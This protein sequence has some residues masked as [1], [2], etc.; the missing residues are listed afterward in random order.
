[1]SIHWGKLSWKYSHKILYG[2]GRCTG[3][4]NV[5]SIDFDF[6]LANTVCFSREKKIRFRFNGSIKKKW[7][8]IKEAMRPLHALS[9]FTGSYKMRSL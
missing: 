5:N 4:K 2:T 8:N 6:L 7:F 3:T 1:M 9:L